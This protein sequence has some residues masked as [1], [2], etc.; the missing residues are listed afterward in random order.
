MKNAPEGAF[1]MLY[2]GVDVLRIRTQQDP[3]NSNCIYLSLEKPKI[4]SCNI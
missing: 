1:C 2:G 3:M 4:D